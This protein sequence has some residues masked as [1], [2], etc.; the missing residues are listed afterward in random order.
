LRKTSGVRSEGSSWFGV[1]LEEKSNSM[2]DPED[3][4]KD[5]VTFYPQKMLF[6]NSKEIW[7]SYA[8]G[9]ELQVVE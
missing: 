5:I 7:E 3:P 9:Q 6:I 4:K 1:V 8:E 2:K